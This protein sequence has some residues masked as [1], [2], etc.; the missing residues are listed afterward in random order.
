MFDL[1]ETVAGFDASSL[2]HALRST[3]VSLINMQRANTR[4][5]MDYV[6]FILPNQ[7]PALPEQRNIIQQQILGKAPLSLL[8][9]QRAFERIAKESSIQGVVLVLRGFAMSL[10][11]LQTLRGSITR[12]RE[13]GKR[14]ICFAQS[15][16]NATY[17]VASAADTILLQPG[18]VLSTTGLLQQQT[19]LK[20]GLEAI[21]L[22]AD[23]VA[24]SPYKGAADSFT[25]AEPSPESEEQVNW[26]MDSS[27]GQ[28]IS[29]IGTGR[30]MAQ[31]A[32]RTMIDNAP[33]IDTAAL[34]KGYVDELV[35]EEG[36]ANFLDVENIALWETADQA[37]P[38]P[39]PKSRDQYIAIL[40][41][42]GMIVPG[43]S[44]KPPRNV[45]IPLVGAE[46]MGDLTVTRLVRNL[47]QDEHCKAL[48]LYVDSPG[49]SATASEAITS[50]LDELAKKMP[51]VVYMSSV[52]ASG[53]YYIATPADYIVAQPGTITGSIGVLNMKLISTEALR[54][55][56][57]NPYIYQR[58][59]NA[60][61]F[62]P[63]NPFTERERDK[64]QQSVERI[65]QQFI[66]RVGNAR[67][68]KTETV[69][70]IGA[71][72]VWTGQQALENGLVDELGGLYE[73]VAKA[74]ELAKLSDEA[75][76]AIV[77][78]K[79]K[80]LPAQLAEQLDPAAALQYW[81]A[82]LAH[83]ARGQNLML[84]PSEWRWES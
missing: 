60:A 78:G 80:P 50:A 29:G 26:L 72:R 73:A 10:A 30:G 33:Y 44:A 53:G 62:A 39:M 24:I 18:G 59:E 32:V 77:R 40:P 19:F 4:L 57:F 41:A 61:I 6:Q 74:R 64:V 5:E 71:G 9:L 56:K 55:L 14:V 15:Y 45:P 16:D 70:A 12:L 83:I 81:Q 36:L 11:D 47:M 22:Q 3:A 66:E 42:T 65:Y 46:R 7:M 2:T 43:E 8:G 51:L 35:T 49:G 68:M 34:E 67:K 75:P 38:L 1:T 20:E 52:A 23:V 54:K 27:F 63:I 84:M 48:V 17:Y 58:G 21:G 82:G 28:L 37:L 76:A 25:R 13:R 31:D 79:G 69:D